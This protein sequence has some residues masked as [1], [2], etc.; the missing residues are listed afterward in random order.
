MNQNQ[1]DMGYQDGL[2]DYGRCKNILIMFSQS[3]IFGLLCCDY[4]HTLI[5]LIQKLF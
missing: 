3:V 4:H 1:A 2:S 5:I